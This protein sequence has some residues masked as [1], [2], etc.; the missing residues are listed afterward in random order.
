MMT[1][2]RTPTMTRTHNNCTVGACTWHASTAPPQAVVS[3]GTT[4][5]WPDHPGA[6]AHDD[7]PGPSDERVEPEGAAEVDLE[8]AARSEEFASAPQ[9]PAQDPPHSAKT[10]I[11]V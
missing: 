8:E 9:V 5:T 11:P 2:Q 7:Q 3:I 1:L 10:S 4:S 6:H